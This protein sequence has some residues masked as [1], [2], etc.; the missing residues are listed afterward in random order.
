MARAELVGYDELIGGL[1]PDLMGYDEQIGDDDDD[2]EVGDIIG[3]KKQKRVRKTA[4]V[5][6]DRR[7]AMGLG[8]V[9]VAAGATATLRGAPSLRFRVDRL[10][11]VPTAPG[12]LVTSVIAG[13]VS[14]TLGGNGSPVE[15]FGPDAFGASFQGQTL[16]P[17]VE[18]VVTIQN[19]TGGDIGVSGTVLGLS[20]Q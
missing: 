8:A 9:L 7:Y 13:N 14:Q 3:R 5:K 10:M 17:A 18:V 2:D 15:A 12:L 19:P 20:D 16:S 4:V 1:D 6:A 11:L